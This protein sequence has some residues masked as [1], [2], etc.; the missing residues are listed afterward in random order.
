MGEDFTSSIRPFRRFSN[1][2]LIPAPACSSAR[3]SVRRVTLRSTRR[4]VAA[5]DAQR[6][7]FHHGGLADAR[8]AGEDRVVLPP[9]RQDV[10][11]LADLEIAAEHRVDLAR[12]W[13]SR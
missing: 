1:S 11:D 8:F 10:D 6:E 3:S 5:R 2:P 12:S 13:R 7:T 4:H 9:A